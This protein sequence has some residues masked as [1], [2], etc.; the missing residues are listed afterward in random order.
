MRESGGGGVCGCVR[1]H[2]RA[3]VVCFCDLNGCSKSDSITQAPTRHLGPNGLQPP[4]F[5]LVALDGAE[6]L[7]GCVHV[8]LTRMRIWV[9]REVVRY[10]M[11]A[12]AMTAAMGIQKKQQAT[13]KAGSVALQTRNYRSNVGVA[14]CS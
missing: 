7:P 11:I 4:S 1:A 12:F 5:H 14:C 2:A 8:Y 13:I 9:I 6:I 3:C 10:R